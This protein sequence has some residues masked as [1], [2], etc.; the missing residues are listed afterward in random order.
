MAQKAQDPKDD[1]NYLFKTPSE[2]LVFFGET[3]PERIGNAIAFAR[4]R[5]VVQ[6][7]GNQITADEYE[8]LKACMQNCISVEV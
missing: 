6:R 4:I 3:E 8:T 7:F 1:P 5:N 2:E